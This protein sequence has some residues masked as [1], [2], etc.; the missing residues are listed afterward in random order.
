MRSLAAI[1]RQLARL[2][3]ANP[4]GMAPEPVTLDIPADKAAEASAL[5]DDLVQA[6]ATLPAPTAVGRYQVVPSL[7]PEHWSALDSIT[8]LSTQLVNLQAL[9]SGARPEEVKPHGL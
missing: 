9:R 3:G 1:E 5:I 4:T 7:G 6:S 8:A 2:R